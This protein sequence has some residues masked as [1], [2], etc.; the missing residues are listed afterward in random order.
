VNGYCDPINGTCVCTSGFLG[1]ECDSR[2][3]TSNCTLSC[4]CNDSALCSNNTSL[5]TDQYINIT[6]NN[7]SISNNN[8]NETIINNN[9]VVVQSSIFV[10]G[11]VLIIGNMSI[12]NSTLELNASVLIKGDFNF[13]NSSLFFFSNSSIVVGGCIYLKNN[14]ITVNL[15]AYNLERKNV[16][17]IKSNSSCLY[18]G[19]VMFKFSNVPQCNSI[20]ESYQDGSL[21]LL[22]NKINNCETSNGIILKE[23]SKILYL[24]LFT[25][26]MY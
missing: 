18:E 23:I 8:N 16:V 19:N 24:I 9:L 26:L 1:V 7:I 14:L 15:S 13:S 21:L 2:C 10:Q 5:C 11:S 4:V 3:I 12:D 17:L 6:N 20:S 25:I 22:F